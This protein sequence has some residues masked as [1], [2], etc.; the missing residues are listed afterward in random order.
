MGIP[1]TRI[2]RNGISL[3]E[4]IGVTACLAAGLFAGCWLFIKDD[5]Q[6]AD[7]GN[8]ER[9]S[10]PATPTEAT[11]TSAPTTEEAELRSIQQNIIDE[12]NASR[13]ALPAADDQQPSVSQPNSPSIDQS[14]VRALLGEDQS[15]PSKSRQSAGS[16]P[17]RPSKKQTASLEADSAPSPA[18]S[19]G[20]Q[21]LAYWNAMNNV[22]AEEES[23]R[24]TPAGGLT[25]E[26]AADFIDRRGKA[27]NYAATELRG[28]DRSGVDPD[29]VALG[30]DIAAWYER[31]AQLN[32]RANYLL[33]Q[34][35]DDTRRGQMGHNWGDSEKAH[36]ASVAEINRRGDT[37]RLQMSQK[38]GLKF[39]DLR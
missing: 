38:Y 16:Q 28:L 3:P 23:M 26:N 35:S 27:G 10:T 19:N 5:A 17:T 32:D 29:V 36:N 22:M 37:L 9:N 34:A 18:S 8:R 2:Q 6:L 13:G 1:I 24:A 14:E 31:G 15:S 21:T 4:V 11:E 39:P 12:I 7:I 25:K 20:P 30:G 33:N